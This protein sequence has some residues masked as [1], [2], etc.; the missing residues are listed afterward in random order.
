MTVQVEQ[1]PL[2]DR[3]SSWQPHQ[4]RIVVRSDIPEPEKIWAFIDAVMNALYSCI[5]ATPRRSDQAAYQ[6][7]CSSCAFELTYVLLQAGLIKKLTLQEWEEY[8]H[9][10]KQ[11]EPE[12]DELWVEGAVVDDTES[13]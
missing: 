5:N 2:R 4:E 13:W 12:A 9:Y 10:Q 6:A 11:I 8:Q 1:Q 7:F 3:L